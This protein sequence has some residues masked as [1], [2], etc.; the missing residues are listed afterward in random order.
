MNGYTIQLLIPFASFL[1]FM[2][3]FLSIPTIL[4]VAHS[5]NLFDE[6]NKRSVHRM[7]I[8]TLGGL[9][10]FIGFL[11]TYSLFVDWFQ[12]IEIPFLIPALLII[13]GIGIKD[14]I[15]VTAP[16]VKL[17]G[18]L[19]AVIIVVG[20]G[21]LQIT[22]FHGFFGLHPDPFWGTVL[23]IVGMVFII[24]G[25]NLIDG[26]DGLAAITGIITSLSFSVWYFINEDYHIPTLVAAL[27]GGLLAFA[28]YNIFSKRQKIFM[29]DTGS[30]IL[31][32][33]IAVV[34]VHFSEFNRPDNQY[35]LLHTMNSAPAVAIAILI[36]PII[37]TLRVFMLRVA[38]GNSPF[39][40]DKNHI[41]HRMLAL[42]FSH[43][44]I[45]LIIGSI[46]IAFVILAFS[47]RNWGML[48]LSILILSL[49]FAVAYIPSVV[50]YYK[51][52]HFIRRLRQMKN[53]K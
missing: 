53:R 21:G 1:S 45:S 6:P 24:N 9:A 26:I 44:Q 16:M 12:F 13:F 28:Y 43:L 3:V 49:G 20:L 8:P 40:A 4:R 51:R 41:H 2:M 22:D 47:L 37:D 27:V 18:Q 31:G 7:R 15:L 30:L 29:G 42:G 23:T 32:F 17:A 46:N 19:I 5:K 36:V 35:K 33:L 11:F 10:I 48:R 38:Q 39:A 52:R 14:D 25:F 34:A 50:L